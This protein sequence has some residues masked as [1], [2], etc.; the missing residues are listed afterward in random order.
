MPSS[1]LALA[2]M[3]AAHGFFDDP[4]Y[5]PWLDERLAGS[6]ADIYLVPAF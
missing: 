1:L 4:A 5:K 2:S 3:A 6:K